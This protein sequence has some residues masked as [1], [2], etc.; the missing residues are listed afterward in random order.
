MKI[1]LIIPAYN[2]AE[3][4]ERVINSLITR[5]PQYDY[6]IINDG[7]KDNTEE[8]CKKNNYN[9]MSHPINLGLAGAVKTGMMYAYENG[10]DAAI[11]FDADGQHDADF[12]DTMATSLSEG[13]NIVI[14]SRFVT[15]KK[16]FS[17]RMLGSNLI[18][19]AILLTT[20]KRIKDSTSGMRMFD[21]QTIARLA[22]AFDLGPEPDTIALLIR[23]GAKIKEV[24]VEMHDRIA[25]ESYLNLSRSISYMTRMFISIIILQWFRSGK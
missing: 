23:S 3:N 16:P 21:K 13:Y 25:G 9:Y 12:I 8:I 11:Q 14:G 17:L 5:Y 4:L 10:Y 6:I 24:Q 2:E 20:G 18:E 7:S 19:I 15:Q 22:S 1:L